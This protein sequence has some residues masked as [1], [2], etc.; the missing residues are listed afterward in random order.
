[1]ISLLKGMFVT[2]KNM[3]HRAVTLQYPTKRWT[4][5]ERM[6]GLV[7]LRPEKCIMCLQCQKACP[8][9]CLRVNFST[10][11]DKKKKLESFVYEMQLCCFC[12]LCVEPCPT[13][14]VYMNHE[15][16]VGLYDRSQ[17]VIDLNKGYK[18]LGW[19]DKRPK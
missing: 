5:P 10:G 17:F 15:Y 8:S 9:G 18:A 14:A 3:L 4:M 16:E 19:F 6:R 11:E 2:I 12:G 1:M 13:A 7:D